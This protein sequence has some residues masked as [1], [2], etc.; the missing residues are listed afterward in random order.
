MRL[1]L[2]YICDR[3]CVCSFFVILLKFAIILLINHDDRIRCQIWTVH[4]VDEIDY[5]PGHQLSVPST[6]CSFS[7]SHCARTPRAFV[8][9]PAFCQT[10]RLNIFDSKSSWKDSQ[11]K[12]PVLTGNCIISICS[13]AADR[14][15]TLVVQISHSFQVTNRGTIKPQVLR[16][17]LI[18]LQPFDAY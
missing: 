7:S 8:C 5:I 15:I 1:G 18:Y 13:F 3:E 16:I 10:L 2:E 14:H 17:S 6:L 9:Y 12:I 4:Q 11:A